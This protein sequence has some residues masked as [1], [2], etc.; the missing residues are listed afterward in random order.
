[1]S[2]SYDHLLYCL[3]TFDCHKFSFFDQID[4]IKAG[5]DSNLDHH[6]HDC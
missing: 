4:T 1:M 2:S 3:I 5:S 6:D